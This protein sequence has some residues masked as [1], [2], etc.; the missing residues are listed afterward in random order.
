MPY[1]AVITGIGLLTP[2]G[3]NPREFFHRASEGHSGIHLITKFDI[4][5]L[6]V[7]V[8]G[9]ISFTEID[10]E[11]MKQWSDYP[12]VTQWSLHATRLC[13]QDAH[14]EPT[15]HRQIDVIIGN[16]FPSFSHMQHWEA[17]QLEQIR[18]RDVSQFNVAATAAVISHEFNFL[19]ETINL[20]TACSSSTTAIGHALRAIQHGDS[21]LVLTGGTE[22]A[23]S[24][25]FLSGLG[26]DNFL[27][28][29]ATNPAQ[30]SRPFDRNRNGGVLGDSACM[31]MLEEYDHACRRGARI[32]AEVK[33]FGTTTGTGKINFES[34]AIDAINR[35][36]NN[37][38]INAEELDY[39][40][41]MGVSDPKL[42]IKETKILKSA[43]RE[44]AWSLPVSSIKSM[45]GNPLGAAG[46]IQAASCALSI[47]N[48]T[49][50]PTINYEE[51]DPECDLD[52]VPNES[53]H[54]KLRNTMLY[55]VGNGGHHAA[56][57]LSAA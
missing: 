32:Y 4:P 46:A 36:L 8:G 15:E 38:K 42:D 18:E 37:A 13:F 44:H 20:C 34:A 49:I 7:Q 39:Y 40:S 41:A 33:G 35:A 30:A 27:C 12:Q 9:Q 29:E 48:Q 17:M 31:L 28:R 51:P 26:H 14:I 6:P 24:P 43:F 11:S 5:K 23:L 10:R 16:S 54:A 50:L 55:T 22:E 52:Y 25:L 56:L 1:R 57:V 19:G 45:I 3:T 53:R 47:V 2:L 21:Q